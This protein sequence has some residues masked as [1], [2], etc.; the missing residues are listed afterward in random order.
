[1][2]SWMPLQAC[3]LLLLAAASSAHAVTYASVDGHPDPVILNV[4]E[5]VT[6][7]FDVAKAGGTVNW[8]IVRDIART[9]KWNPP[10]PII[11]NSVAT[12]GGP[13]DADP[14]PGKIALPFV[15]GVVFPPGLYLLHLDDQTDGSR[16]DA[17][18]WS[19]V[20]KPE[21]QSI[22]G[23]V[24]VFSDARPDGTP[25]SDAVIWAYSDART[26]VAATNIRPDGTYT[27][28]LPAGTYLLFAEWFGDL[29]SQRQAMNLVAGQQRTGV[30]LALIQGQEVT[31]KVTAG[32]QQVGGAPVQATST[33]GRDYVTR[34]FS[35]GTYTLILPH[36][37]YRITSAGISETVVVG[38]GP[39]DSVDFPPPGPAPTPAAGSIVTVAGNG[40]DGFGGDGRLAVT[41][42]LGTP[43]PLAIDRAGNLYFGDTVLNRVRKVDA[44]SGVI[45]TV[46]GSSRIDRIRG[47]FPVGNTGGFSGDGG[48]AT[49][50]LLDRPQNLTLDAVGNLYISESG[51]NRVRRVD[52]KTGVITTVAGSGTIGFGLGSFSG[53]G[54]P[55][56]S[57][58]MNAPLDIVVDRAGNLYIADN[59]NRRIRK[60]S[61]NGIITTFAGGGTDPVT[62]GA[63]ATAVA[64][65]PIQMAIDGAGN[66]YTND[67]LS[68]RILKI[69][70]SG[71]VTIV[72]GTG[73][74]GFSGDGGPATGATYNAS[75]PYMTVDSAGNLFFSDEFNNRIRKVSPDGIITTVVGNG[76]LGAGRGGFGGDG[77]PATAAQI[78]WP[79]GVGIDAEGNLLLVANARVRKVPGIAAPGLIAGQ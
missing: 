12:D 32:G 62:N 24:L 9:G 26:P 13:L 33:A 68:N 66:L 75:F 64:L 52:A 61:P 59:R 21:A 23:R 46:A 74:V 42:R 25:P 18:G 57:A 79:R 30:D 47:L 5:S 58:T 69:E 55:A 34:T 39:V 72:V 76:P 73:K 67:L 51:N 16:L 37:E 10:D 70:P 63:L 60:V 53:D 3:L 36:G 49:A 11:T 8:R 77:G 19:I 6:I 48:P 38:D 22:S 15:V 71:R 65:R 7:R 43:L 14:T 20:P 41:A 56:T 28:P 4:G 45:T 27:L 2:R 54:G 31:G 78:N 17:A 1:M 44:K 40:I 50:A 35:D 29:R